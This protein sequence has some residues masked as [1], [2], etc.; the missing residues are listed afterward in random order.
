MNFKTNTLISLTALLV[1]QGCVEYRD[2]PACAKANY[3]TFEEFRAKGVEV[4][5]PQEIDKAGKIYVYGDLL[6]VSEANRGVH[7][8]DN[9]DKKNPQP[10]KFLKIPGNLDMAVKDGYLYVDSYMD[11]VVIDIK[12]IENIK[13]VNRKTDT[14]TYDPYQSANGE[15]YFYGQ[16]D[17]DTTKGVIVGGDN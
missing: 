9:S 3:L 11:L 16:C 8:I 13:E 2:D 1:L 17:F 5:P 7:V 12:D 4:L 14:F 15:S 10:K 6:F